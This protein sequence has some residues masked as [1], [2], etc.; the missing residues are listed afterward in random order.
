[1]VT[2]TRDQGD[3]IGR[4]FVDKGNFLFWAIISKI[5]E[6]T[7]IFW[8]LFLTAKVRYYIMA[9]NGLAL[10]FGRIFPDSCR[11]SSNI[12]FW[13][14]IDRQAILN[15]IML[16]DWRH[17]IRP[18][19][20]FSKHAKSPSPNRPGF[21]ARLVGSGLISKNPSLAQAR[22]INPKSLAQARSFLARTSPTQNGHCLFTDGRRPTADAGN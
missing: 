11:A 22:S 13:S 12:H 8:L 19:S 18:G 14:P 15:F 3:Q 21:G 9:T 2:L 16:A 1:V 5:S 17:K 20:G 7:R 10:L 4:I 6:Q